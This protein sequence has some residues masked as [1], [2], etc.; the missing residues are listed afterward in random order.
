MKSTFYGRNALLILMATAFLMP[1][2]WA[3]T[4][5]GVLSNDNDIKTWLPA[6]PRVAGRQQHGV[7]AV[8]LDR[9]TRV[10]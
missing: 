6:A 1:W 3:G 10:F 2:M 4:R 9:S 7:I 5:R 8:R